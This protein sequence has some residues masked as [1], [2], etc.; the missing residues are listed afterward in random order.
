MNFMT[1]KMIK[2]TPKV[3]KKLEEL[4]FFSK[5]GNGHKLH[6]EFFK[7][8][9]SE[10]TR[11]AYYSDIKHFFEF[12]KM[13]FGKSI[14]HPSEVERAHIIAYKDFIISCGG[15][16]QAKA[17]NLT[18]RR[19]ISTLNTYY[20]FLLERDIVKFNPVEGIKRPKKSPNK[21]TNCLSQNQVRLLLDYMDIEVI[22]HNDFTTHLH[23][24]L[25]YVLFYTGIRVSELIKI[26]RQ[27]LSKYNGQYILKIKAKGSKLR[28][29]PIHKELMD[30]IK[31]YMSIVKIELSRTLH[32]DDYLFFSKMNNRN[33]N[34][35]HLSRQGVNKILAKRTFQAGIRENI[36]PH[37][38]RATVITSLLD[39]GHDLYK[40]SLSIGHSN[41]ETTKI[42]DKRNQSVKD[43]AILDLS[44]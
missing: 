23:R 35:I 26:Q 16:D 10:E 24:T 4:E 3:I 6:Y 20:K 18:V 15:K 33:Q 27:D 19:K 28:I 1:S 31:E 36:T 13:A 40:V 14:R 29:V 5:R 8:L 2:H 42:Y 44:Y 22:G 43:N 11:K 37:S 17:S 25:I 32:A 21:G 7:N 12:Y 30:I 9:N 38:A 34:K 39:Q 41:P